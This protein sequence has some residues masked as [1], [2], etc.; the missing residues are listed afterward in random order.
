[1]ADNNKELIARLDAVEKAHKEVAGKANYNP[2]FVL[3]KV[4]SLRKTLAIGPANEAVTKEINMLPLTPAPLSAD[5]KEPVVEKE[6]PKTIA[7]PTSAPGL[8]LKK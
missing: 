1:M 7:P 4:T 3:K 8:N 5:H 2:F 6:V